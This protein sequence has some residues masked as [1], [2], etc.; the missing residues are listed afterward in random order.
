MFSIGFWRKFCGKA[1]LFL[2][3]IVL[4]FI[5][6]YQSFLA[7]FFASGGA[8]R[9]YPSCSEYGFLVYKKYSFFKATGLFFRR[10]LACHPFGPKIRHESELTSEL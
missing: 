6:F 2:K 7:G 1:E 8:C 5:A 3:L 9:F 4:F 10:L